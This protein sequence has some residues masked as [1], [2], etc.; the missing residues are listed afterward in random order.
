MPDVFV[1]GRYTNGYYAEYTKEVYTDYDTAY[2]MA[3]QLNA[4]RPIGEW[5]VLQYQRPVKVRL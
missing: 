4:L 5:V 1:L 3:R 2:G